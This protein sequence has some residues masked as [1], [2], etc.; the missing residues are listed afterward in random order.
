MNPSSSFRGLQPDEILDNKHSRLHRRV[1]FLNSGKLLYFAIAGLKH[2]ELT[3]NKF[4]N[5]L[6]EGTL[7]N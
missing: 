7:N 3:L 6:S 4:T 2:L 1:P 5:W